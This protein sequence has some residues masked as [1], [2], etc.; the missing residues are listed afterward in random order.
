MANE[1][2]KGV[3]LTIDQLLILHYLLDHPEIDTATA[4]HIS[5]RRNI[6]ARESLNQ[7][8]IKLNYLERGGTGKGTYWKLRVEFHKRISTP[9]HLEWDGMGFPD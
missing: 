6:E 2:K 3:V 9:G 7:M 1:G 5:Q 4:A 8:E